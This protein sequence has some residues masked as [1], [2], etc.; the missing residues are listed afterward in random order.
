[1]SNAMSSSDS[2]DEIIISRRRPRIFKA[3]IN[4]NSLQITYEYNERFRINFNQFSFI[5]ERIQGVLQHSTRR[6]YALSPQ[7]QLQVALHWLGSGVQYHCVADMHG[8]EKATVC[9]VIKKVVNAIHDYV[10][11]DVVKWPYDVGLVI[12]EF[13]N[14]ANMP[15]VCG[16]V[17]GTLINIDAPGNFESAYVDRHGQ[18]SINVIVVAG[19][20]LRFY[21]VCANWPGSTSDARVLRNSGLCHRMENRWRPFPDAV[22][23][24]DSIYPLKS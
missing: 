11:Q 18:H 20:D 15:L 14:I 21:Y 4:Y 6:N 7:Q 16:A 13:S 9:R 1:M 23:L 19:A 2:D 12:N 10:L 5:L 22:L 24:G 3:R 8:I 17:D